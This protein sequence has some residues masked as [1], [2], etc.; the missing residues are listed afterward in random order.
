MIKIQSSYRIIKK[1]DISGIEE[2]KAVDTKYEVKREE[3]TEVEIPEE[4]EKDVEEQ[5]EKYDIEELERNIRKSI[6]EE[7]ELERANIINKAN[8]MAEK[9][10][11]EARKLGFDEGRKEGY[12]E[13]YKE[14]YREGIDRTREEA[15]SIKEDA[16]SLISQSEEHVSEYLAEN[17]EKIIQLAADMAES[18]VHHTIDT[19]TDNILMLIKPIL[20]NYD[21]KGNIIISCNSANYDYI[22]KRR[23]E[24]RDICPDSNIV[25]MKDDNLGKN[26]CVLENERQIIDL[27]IK[28][29]I[30][31]ILEE[32][33][34]L[35]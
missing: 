1:E 34:E 12:E 10:K 9:I 11:V 7:T 15:A 32:I 33:R 17:R 30:E 14:G 3:K 19:S 5:E 2:F 13:G 18:I 20:Q 6:Y 22:D 27:Q 16:L 25:I 8:E 24:L 4:D 29:Q 28:K 31:S 23:Q 35:E 21:K 26:D